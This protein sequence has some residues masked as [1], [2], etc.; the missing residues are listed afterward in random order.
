[1][2]LSLDISV[3]FVFAFLSLSLSLYPFP[4]WKV[5]GSIEMS[6]ILVNTF[7]LDLEAFTVSWEGRR[8]KTHYDTFCNGRQ[9]RVLWNQQEGPVVWSEEFRRVR[10]LRSSFLEEICMTQVLNMGHQVKVC[11]NAGRGNIMD[12]MQDS[13]SCALRN[14]SNLVI[15]DHQVK[16]EEDK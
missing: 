10:G 13:S 12:T 5:G 3:A 8:K 4:S 7:V 1:M 9:W 11:Q 2:V 16:D 14:Y 6:K 15:V